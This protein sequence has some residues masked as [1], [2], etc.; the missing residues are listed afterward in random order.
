[1]A[2]LQ[3]ELPINHTRWWRSGTNNLAQ[4]NTVKQ[5]VHKGHYYSIR[6]LLYGFIT[7]ISTHFSTVLLNCSVCYN[8]AILVFIALDVTVQD[9]LYHFRQHMIRSNYPCNNTNYQDVS[10]IL[11]VPTVI[12]LLTSTTRWSFFTYVLSVQNSS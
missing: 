3:S 12:E 11:A 7:N 10:V 8:T 2:P 6:Y 5:R 1:M 9:T 4:Y